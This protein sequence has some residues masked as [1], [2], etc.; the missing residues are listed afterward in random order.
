MVSVDVIMYYD[1]TMDGSINPEDYI[2]GD[3]YAMLVE[4][5][6]FNNDGSIDSCEVH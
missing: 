6:D 5:C 4:Y 2:D 1:T 3:H